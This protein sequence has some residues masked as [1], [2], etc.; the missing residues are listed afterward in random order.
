MNGQKKLPNTLSYCNL[1]LISIDLLVCTCIVR[2][3]YLLCR[4]DGR[5]Y[6]QRCGEILECLLVWDVLELL[7]SISALLA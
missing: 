7:I 5:K 3:L 6:L 1:D 4:D 2:G